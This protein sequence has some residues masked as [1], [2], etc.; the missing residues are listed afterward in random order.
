MPRN[1]TKCGLRA[2]ERVRRKIENIAPF[3]KVCFQDECVEIVFDVLDEP[4]GPAWSQFLIETLSE[5]TE[6]RVVIRR[7]NI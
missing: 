3:A 1:Q 7:S 2:A 5:A 4:L 6:A